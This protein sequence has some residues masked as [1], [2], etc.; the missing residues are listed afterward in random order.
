MW[1]QCHQH[2]HHVMTTASSMTPLHLFCED[3][4]VQHDIF[5]LVMP[6][7]LLLISHDAKGIVND[8][9]AFTRA[10]RLKWHST[11]LF[12]HMVPLAMVLS[13]H[14][15][16]G[17]KTAPLHSLDQDNWN[18]FQHDIFGHDFQHDIFGHVMSLASASWTLTL[19]HHWH[20]HDVMPVASSKW[21]LYS[22]GHTRPTRT[23]QSDQSEALQFCT[24]AFALM[25]S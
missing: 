24:W 3:N 14:D 4:Q 18:D 22:L 20:W 12:D 16:N 8:T 23:T 21:P 6:L 1:C 2:Q 9:N 17:I 11:W 25:R 15:A 19:T 7:E 5:G 10:R 13:S